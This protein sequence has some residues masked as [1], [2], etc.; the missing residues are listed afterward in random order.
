MMDNNLKAACEYVM[1]SGLK[2][3]CD[4]DVG[5]APCIGC[6]VN[7]V[8]RK[9]YDEHP[10]DED[11]PVTEEW[12][13]SIGFSHDK[14]DTPTIGPLH[15]RPPGNSPYACISSYPLPEVPVNRGQ[16][17]RLLAALGIENKEDK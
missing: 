5:C 1:G 17:R 16:V 8:C 9:Y 14:F 4:P 10:A 15:L 2:C 7:E 13:L 12:L 6:C 11:E 3:E